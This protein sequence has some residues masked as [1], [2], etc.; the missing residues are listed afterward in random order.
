MNKIKKNIVIS[1]KLVVLCIL[2]VTSGIA[3][4]NVTKVNN[5]YD[6]YSFI[7][8]G[9][10]TITLLEGEEYKE[11]GY[12]IISMRGIDLSSYVTIS[13]NVNTMISGEYEIKYIADYNKKEKIL[14]RKVNVVPK[15]S[16]DKWIRIPT[17]EGSGEVTH[18]KVLYFESGY[19]GYKYW[20]VNTPYPYNDAYYENPS[21]VVSNDAIEW[22]EPAGIK[23]P[24][25][26]YPNVKRDDSYYSDPFILYNGESFELFFRK[27]KSYENGVY[28]RNGYNYMYYM[29]SL[30][31]YKWSKPKI[32]LNN[33]FGEQY[34]SVSVVKEDNIYKIWYVN[35]N[36]K[37][38]YRE[39]TDLISFTEAVDI[40]IDNFDKKVWHKEIQY[41][42]NKYVCIFMIKY[43]LYYTESDDG[44]HFIEP[45]EIDTALNEMNPYSYNIYKTSFVITDKYIELFVPYRVNYKWKMRYKKISKNDFKN[46]LI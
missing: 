5:I 10:E 31:G 43:K 33:S 8:N 44:T 7:I 4:S 42:D 6:D 24:V 11:P 26:G 32:V 36:G 14:T 38:R 18:P 30:D 3:L 41:V 45:T 9:D 23:N 2:L 1:I 37:I 39:S 27:T 28:K 34:M 29:N 13:S 35:Y 25:S 40:K 16:V 22:I 19:N 46:G 20:M 17:Y 12:E 15:E 21:I